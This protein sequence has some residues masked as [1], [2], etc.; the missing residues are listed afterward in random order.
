MNGQNLINSNS[1]VSN[2]NNI[3]TPP[4]QYNQQTNRT[5]EPQNINMQVQL[6]LFYEEDPTEYAQNV[7]SLEPI[8][9]DYNLCK[10]SSTLNTSNSSNPKLILDH[11]IDKYKMHDYIK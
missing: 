7:Q 8:E 4:S 9:Y 11:L 1:N 2:I 3:N 5:K 10:L 6:G